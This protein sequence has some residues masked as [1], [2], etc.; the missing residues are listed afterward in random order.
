MAEELTNRE[1]A[2]L[3][4]I[5]G[6]LSEHQYPPSMR[7]IASALGSDSPNTARHLI[8]KLEEK[9]YVKKTPY[10]PRSLRVIG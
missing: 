1:M 5:K 4:F 3:G 7:E 8:T 6:Y 2:A 9:G 10:Q